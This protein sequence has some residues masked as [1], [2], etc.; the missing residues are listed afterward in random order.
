MPQEI[1]IREDGTK[2]VCTV[3][4]PEED[5]SRTV[6][7]D[8]H[9]AE[10][11]HILRKYEALGFVDHM[12]NVD[13]QYRDVTEFDDFADLMRQ[14]KDAEASFMKLPSKVREVFDHD[15]AKW[16]DAAHDADKLEALRPQLEKL[17]VLDPASAPLAPPAAPATETS[18][19]ADAG[20]GGAE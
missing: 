8:R 20:S 2:R 16:L 6:Q 4:D 1:T 17:G 5:P 10:M 14:S 3:Y 11:K 7:S 15:Y 9:N 18:T 12:A 19:T 13:L